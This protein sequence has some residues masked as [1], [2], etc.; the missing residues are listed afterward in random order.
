[1]VV[2]PMGD[3]TTP[4]FV[5]FRESPGAVASWKE[6]A[7]PSVLKCYFK[8]SCG[9]SEKTDSIIRKPLQGAFEHPPQPLQEELDSIHLCRQTTFWH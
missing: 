6:L 9:S 7:Y 3:L 2:G 4:H 5:N 8:A 1:M